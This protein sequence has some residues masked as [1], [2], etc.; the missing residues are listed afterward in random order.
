[1][2]TALL[3]G[4]T[5]LVVEDNAAN[6]LMLRCRLESDSACVLGPAPSSEIALSLIGQTQCDLAVVD[7]FLQGETAQP[8]IDELDKRGVPRVIITAAVR[9]HLPPSISGSTILMQPFTSDALIAAMAE[10]LQR[11]ADVSILQAQRV[12]RRNSRKQKASS[13]PEIEGFLQL[14]EAA[15]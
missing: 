2:P 3:R 8:V 9:E 6:A 14:Q 5:I 12:K 4:L 11:K 1:M 13:K 7:F 10:V 15:E